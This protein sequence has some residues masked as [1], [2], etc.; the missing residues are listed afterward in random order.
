L[1]LIDQ[2]LKIFSSETA[3]PN[4]PKL[5]RKHLWKV[6]YENC[7]I[8][9]DPLTNM[10][11]T[12]E[13]QE[14][15]MTAIFVNGSKGISNSHRGPSIDT[16][17]HVSVHLAMLFQSRRFLEIDQSETRMVISKKSSPLKPLCQMNRNLVGS[18]YGRFSI[19]IAHLVPI[20]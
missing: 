9:P 1:F 10:A 4:D 7:S 18:I 12:G 16:S 20:Y 14:L 6:L 11:T 19:K 3:W 8:R 17:Y 15:P 13:K 5:D 2:F